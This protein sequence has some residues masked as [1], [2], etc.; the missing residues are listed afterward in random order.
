MQTF[1]KVLIQLT[2]DNYELSREGHNKGDIIPAE[3]EYVN[4]DAKNSVWFGGKNG[5]SDCIA[6]LGDNAEIVDVIAK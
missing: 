3:R 4:G 1:R 2:A 5:A 6:Y